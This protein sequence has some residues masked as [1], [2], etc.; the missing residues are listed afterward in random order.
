MTSQRNKPRG[1]ATRRDQAAT[2]PAVLRPA[3]DGGG[4]P[5]DP[6]AG[7]RELPGD[8]AAAVRASVLAVG[9][10]RTTLTDVARRA[11]VSRMTLY[12]LVPD[13]ETLLLDV[14]TR[15]L[16][17]LLTEIEAGVARRRTA[18]SRLVAQLVEAARR[19]PDEPLFRRVLDVDPEL[20]LPYLTVRIGSTQQLALARIRRVIA[21]GHADRSIRRGNLDL[22]ATSLL[23]TALPWIVSARLFDAVGRDA[24]LGELERGLEGWLEP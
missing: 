4:E 3:P 8:V 1:P 22:M 21:E 7:H 19:L 10:R 17:A 2:R 6:A 23:M 9:V 15:D 13:V 11:G 14:L 24:A 5:A 16:A 20:L 18:R 12:R